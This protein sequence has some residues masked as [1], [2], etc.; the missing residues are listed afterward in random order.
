[1]TAVI[2]VFFDE[3]SLITSG[4]NEGE[5]TKRVVD[6]V[7][8]IEIQNAFPTRYTLHATYLFSPLR[9]EPSSRIFLI[10]EQPNPW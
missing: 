10:G 6:S 2:N 8:R 5:I 9:F 1:M 3:L 4:S 7:E